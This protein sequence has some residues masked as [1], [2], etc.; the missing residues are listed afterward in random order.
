M[1]D[2]NLQYY[3]EL[4][5]MKGILHRVELFLL[6]YSG[7]AT[8]IQHYD[9]SGPTPIQLKH[10]GSDVDSWD[11]SVIQ[12]QELIFDFYVTQ[13][14]VAAFDSLFESD[15][16]DYKVRYYI[17]SQLEFEGWVKPENLN[18][19]FLKSPPNVH[20]S[21]SATD[22]LAELKNIEYRDS[23][24]KLINGVTSQLQSIKN[25]VALT[26]IEFDFY[27]QLNTYETT[28]MFS[29][30]CALEKILIN[31][32]RFYEITDKIV[33]I[34]HGTP[35]KAWDVIECILR[36][37]NCKFLQY[38]GRYQ[39]SNRHE[40]DSYCFV[41]DYT[42]LAEASAI[43]TDN[44]VDISAYDV[45]PE[46]NQQKVRPLKK[47]DI[48]FKNKDL[49][50][51]V[52]GLDLSDWSTVWVKD[53]LSWSQ[54]DGIVDLISDNSSGYSDSITLTS[55]FSVTKVT[56]SDYIRIS[57][58]RKLLSMTYSGKKPVVKMLIQIKTPDGIWHSAV[59]SSCYTTN[60]EH[61][62]SEV[63]PQFLVTAT[64]NYNIKITFT[65]SVWE[66]DSATFQIKNVE[67]VKP[68]NA[69]EETNYDNVTYDQ[70]FVQVN[71]TGFDVLELD[72]IIADGA[73]ITEAGTLLFD[74]SGTTVVTSNWCRYGETETLLLLDVFAHNVLDNRYG[75]KNILSTTIIDRDHTLGLNTIVTIDGRYY[76]FLSFNKNGILG[77]IE[78]ELI[79]LLP[80][81]RNYSEVA[82]LQLDS[83]NGETLRTMGATILTSSTIPDIFLQ[84][85]GDTAIGSYVFDT[86]TLFID[87]VHHC[88]GIKTLSPEGHSLTVNAADGNCLRLI[89][90]DEDSGPTTYADFS[91]T[92]DGYLSLDTSG[93]RVAL[94]TD[95]MYIAAGGL[96]VGNE[97]F[98]AGIVN[99]G[100][101]FRIANAA[102]DGAIL[103]GDGTNFVSSG[104]A[105][106]TKTD[107]D[108]VTLTLGGSPTNALVTATSLTLGWTGQLSVARG[109]T[110][111]A[112]T[113]AYAVL[114]GGTTSTGALQALA[115]LGTAS[116]VLT[117][118]GN[119]ALP[120]FQAASTGYWTANVNDISNN[121]SG[122]VIIMA[123]LR[124]T[125]SESGFIKFIAPQYPDE[126]I[127]TLPESDG[128]NGQCLITN[129]SGVLSWGNTSGS[130]VYPDA[131]IP[132]STGSAWDSSI[133]DSHTNWDT[134]YTHSQSNSQSHTD[135]L[136]NNGSDTTSGALTATNFVLSSDKRMK[137]KIEP[138]NIEW[139]D[140]DYK[141]F[142]LKSD[143]G[144]K[145]FGVIAQDIKNRYPELTRVDDNGMLSV[146]YID[147][148]IRE[149]AYLKKTVKQLKCKL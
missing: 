92:S 101:G 128:N 96:S 149:I 37:Y 74:N 52:S 84:N 119:G 39:I 118:N 32:A 79:E 61:Y 114:C 89:Y 136:I 129:G 148:I 60:W 115:S 138:L 18:K 91:V 135:Y 34:I 27:I 6:E 103:R 99:V 112:S 63:S 3:A 78:A 51:D 8:A 54:A 50:G 59:Q 120:S 68:V 21:L 133:T 116:Q 45:F 97:N 109:G 64:G 123:G 94:P 83:V 46:V 95:N 90:N 141:E 30:E 88:I 48:T 5:D 28:Y 113:T 104:A 70:R 36:E 42:T 137:T 98:A 67:I 26:G 142:E 2:Y 58:D 122:D 73:Q 19:E 16:R 87:S 40:L 66:W 65:S 77:E 17:N 33:G 111:L 127:F 31:N 106:L 10:L 110:G 47:V 76:E 102:A 35:M 139:L 23:T 7:G 130:M 62:A 20:I 140:I 144:Q 15:Y 75:F 41:Y 53:F 56:K 49:G 43:P 38:K 108:N 124:L 85:N 29:D 131:G 107:D 121:N 143:K 72:A 126:T 44:I 12:G 57:F 25:A 55:D 134:A 147:L 11:T 24:G 146:A 9:G 80:T 1:V 82:I 100:T 4:Y 14:E 93:G 132:I 105:A 69:L 125:G 22:G 13:A 117:S 81:K 71:T 145:R 86:N